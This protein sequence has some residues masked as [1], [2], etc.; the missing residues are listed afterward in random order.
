LRHQDEVERRVVTTVA[1]REE[2]SFG[3]RELGLWVADSDA[4][5]IWLRLPEAEDPAAAE[6]AIV[7]GLRER[8]V[9][10]RPGAALGE[11]G[12]LRVTVGTEQE[13]KK[14]LAALAELI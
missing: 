13:N 9:L 10:V 12:A 14:F 6:A 8:D 11:V 1:G 5:F 4:N 7:K 2:L 3:V